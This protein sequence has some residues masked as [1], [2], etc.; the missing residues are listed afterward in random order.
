MRYLKNA[1]KSHPAVAECQIIALEDICSNF[2]EYRKIEKA[3]RAPYHTLTYH[4]NTGNI[5]ASFS[6]YKEE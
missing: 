2:F 6:I 1:V 3:L 5:T 4:K